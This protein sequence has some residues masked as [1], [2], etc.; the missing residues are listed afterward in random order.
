MK[1]IYWIKYIGLTIF[2]ITLVSIN[3]CLILSQ[4]FDFN[5]SPFAIGDAIADKSSDWII[6]YL[7]GNNSISRVV[8]VFPNTLIFKPSMLAV[9]ILLI[10][11]WIKNKNLI[12]ELDEN[13]L[14]T[15][16]IIIFGILSAICLIFHALV[17]GTEL[18]NGVIKKIRRIILLLFI[19]FEVVAQA[20]LLII[21]YKIKNKILNL[22]SIKFLFFKRCLVTTLIITIIISAPFVSMPGNTAFKHILEW[23]YFLA[24]VFFYLLTFFMWKKI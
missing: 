10:F 22:I 20:Y 19:I 2:L 14:H 15:K 23:N 5:N 6:P 9:G 1:D 13:Q 18:D 16:K 12:L 7:D 8:R 17:L 11:Y 24:V 3:S 21:F 4:S